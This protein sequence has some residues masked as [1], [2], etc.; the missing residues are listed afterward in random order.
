MRH[1]AAFRALHTFAIAAGGLCLATLATHASAANTQAVCAPTLSPNVNSC[2]LDLGSVT[3]TAPNLAF[4]TGPAYFDGDTGYINLAQTDI[5]STPNGPGV[6]FNPAYSKLYGGSG[7][8]E[9]ASGHL[10]F[11]GVETTAAPGYTLNSVTV[12]FEG[13]ASISGPATIELWPYMST[14]QVVRFSGEGDHAFDLSYTLDAASLGPSLFPSLMWAGTVP[15][16][17]GPNGT[18]TVSSML[19]LSFKKIT[20]TASVTPVPE[21]STWAMLS[22]GL[23]GVASRARTR[24]RA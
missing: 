16:G 18:A 9:S 10:R 3:F 24:R 20:I 6:T 5:V 2:S 1:A 13:V 14:G 7:Q 4:G 22:L 21:A 19:N 8:Y 11:A 12:R 15:Y 23:L 17:Q